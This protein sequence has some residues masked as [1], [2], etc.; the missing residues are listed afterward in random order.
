MD[1]VDYLRAWLFRNRIGTILYLF[2]LTRS[3]YAPSDLD[4]LP[5]NKWDMLYTCFDAVF[6]A[7]WGNM[8]YAWFSRTDETQIE[9][10]GSM[11]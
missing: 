3:G 8:G 5:E 10:A 9:L 4:E 7:I 1:N 11:A 6:F 2:D